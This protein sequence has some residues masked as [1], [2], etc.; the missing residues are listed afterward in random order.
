MA[1]YIA[2]NVEN[3]YIPDSLI[4]RIQK[5]PD[6]VRECTQVASEMVATLKQKGFS[7]V[8]LATIGWEDK[9]PEILT[10]LKGSK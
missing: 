10:G 3:V 9:L 1:R 8:L 2:R 5:S 4:D 7:G 6:K